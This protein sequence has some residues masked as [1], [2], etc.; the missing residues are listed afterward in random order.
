MGSIFHRLATVLILTGL[1]VLNHQLCAHFIRPT[2]LPLLF[3]TTEQRLLHSISDG[4]RTVNTPAT[5]PLEKI[6]NSFSVDN[7]AYN[8]NSM[9]YLHSS[10]KLFNNTFDLLVSLSLQLIGLFLMDILKVTDFQVRH[11]DWY[12]TLS[13][14]TISLLYILPSYFLYYWLFQTSSAGTSGRIGTRLNDAF[15]T[16][17]YKIMGS[18]MIWLASLY[19]IFQTTL[20]PS[21]DCN[22]MQTSLY[23]ISLFGVSCI[24][25]LNGIGC[26]MGCTDLWEHY[27]GHDEGNIQKK[28]LELTFEIQSLEMHLVSSTDESKSSSSSAEH[29]WNKLIIIDSLLRDIN[30]HKQSQLGIYNFIKV[31]SW[32]YCFYKVLYGSFRLLQR[33]YYAIVVIHD[34]IDNDHKGSAISSGAFYDG[35]GDFLSITI[36]KV[37][38]VVCSKSSIYETY[39][40][41]FEA[42]SVK[43]ELISMIINFIISIIFF[44][45]SFQNVL[46]TMKNFKNISKTATNLFNFKLDLNND[47]SSHMKTEW[48][49]WQDINESFYKLTS[50]FICEMTG[51]YVV[52][53]ALLL[54]SKNM[55]LHL[56]QIYIEDEN[57]WKSIKSYSERDGGSIDIEFMNNWFD[58]W[59]AVGAVATL[60]AIIAVRHLKTRYNNDF[61]NVV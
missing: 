60:G 2:L 5:F 48:N 46:L 8:A 33:V 23:M 18:I 19:L 3:T 40:E 12:F 55:P 47:S 49:F 6:K 16:D 54:N 15:R 26:V 61:N 9:G 52:S 10:S 30:F 27:K 13:V 42:H 59:F 25:S 58:R 14:L 32:G 24:S 1:H 51:I 22:I 44:V 20:N 28:E 7:N 45:F 57:E 50:L 34:V 29:L 39:E 11:L 56:S 37:V 43:L 35:S 53:T 41:M 36:A 38:L 4:L 17:Y 31:S 21:L